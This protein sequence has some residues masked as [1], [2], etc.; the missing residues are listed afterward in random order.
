M[1]FTGIV[2]AMGRVIKVDRQRGVKLWDGS[3]GAS[4]TLRIEVAPE[5]VQTEA[6]EEDKNRQGGTQDNTSNGNQRV[7]KIL[8]PRT[9]IGESIAVEGVC[10][11]VTAFSLQDRWFEC[12]VA[13]HTIDITTYGSE[14]NVEGQAV[15]LE[16]AYDGSSGISGHEVQ[17][18]VDCTAKIL[19]MRFDRDNLVLTFELPERL[20][21]LV[22]LKG[23]VAIDGAS[24]TVC[25]VGP[26]FFEVMLVPHTQSMITLAKKKV[27]EPVN[28]EAHVIGK[29]IKPMVEQALLARQ[30]RGKP[31]LSTYLSIAALGVSCLTAL[32][33]ARS[34]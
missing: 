26:G 27:G 30:A 17:G 9:Y 29:Y 28:V 20:D 11:T 32:Y 21:N 3:V 33:V 15:N 10:L 25:N 6:C 18:H 7:A 22:I 5:S 19:N 1:G 16:C 34:R 23:Y 24:L 4:H 13:G 14:I 8:T 12:N 31:E 2:Q